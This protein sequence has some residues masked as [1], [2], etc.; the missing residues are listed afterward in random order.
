MKLFLLNWGFKEEDIVMLRDDASNRRQIPTR[1]NIIDAFGWL[2]KGAKANDNLVLHYSGHGG[3]TEDL[4]G[5]EDDGY[6]ECLYP[7]DFETSGFIVDDE[8]HDRVVKPLPQGCRLTALIDACHSATM[9]DL[10]YIYSTKGVVKEPNLYSEAGQDVM[11]VVQG[12]LSGNQKNM[13]SGVKSLVKTIANK[14]KAAK[15]REYT[16]QSKTSP[17]DVISISGCKDDQTSADAKEAGQ[18]TGAMSYAFI[19]V[20]STN[21]QQSYISLLQNMR[22]VLSGKY[23]QK[24]QLS[25]S[26]PI[27]TNLQFII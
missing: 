21:P 24:P 22:D 7:L 17:A 16:K 12:Y 10:P 20:M 1:Q 23:T 18:N 8:I 6:D 9:L 11:T 4:N 5:D 2:V 3:Q 14:D 19:R 25:S 15:A 27:D 26:H 13:F